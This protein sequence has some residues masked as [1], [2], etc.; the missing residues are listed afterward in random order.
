MVLSPA[1]G[2]GSQ[3]LAGRQLQRLRQPVVGS[4]QHRPAISHAD[5]LA[6]AAAL[7]VSADSATKGLLL[8]AAGANKDSD[9]AAMGLN[10]CSPLQSSGAQLAGQ[11]SF[12]L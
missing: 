6:S 10:A 9:T 4:L 11:R 3:E 7:L 12:R 2:G 1:G 5:M 8:A